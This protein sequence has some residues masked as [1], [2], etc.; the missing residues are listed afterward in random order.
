MGYR[1]IRNTVVPVVLLRI[2]PAANYVYRVRV[3][4]TACVVVPER[5]TE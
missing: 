1:T 4:Q 2:L 5:D 3:D